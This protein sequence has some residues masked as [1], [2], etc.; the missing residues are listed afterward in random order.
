LVKRTML[1]DPST[2]FNVWTKFHEDE[3]LGLVFYVDID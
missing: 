3:D 1:S 2:V